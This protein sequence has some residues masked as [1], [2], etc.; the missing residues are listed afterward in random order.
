VLILHS[1]V[2]HCDD[3][4]CVYIFNVGIPLQLLS[5]RVNVASV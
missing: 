2:V 1:D 4:G 3:H 5:L